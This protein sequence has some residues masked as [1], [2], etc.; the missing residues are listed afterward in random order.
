MKKIACFIL[1][2]FPLHEFI[3]AQAIIEV[4]RSAHSFA[5]SSTD[6]TATIIY[7]AIEDSLVHKT[8]ALLKKDIEVVSDKSI[9]VATSLPSAGNIIIIG[10]IGTSLFIKQL[11]K[12]KKINVS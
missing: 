6:Q 11:I 8:V 9:H 1:L 4:N 10:N 2:L 7:D 12:E 3:H 5:I